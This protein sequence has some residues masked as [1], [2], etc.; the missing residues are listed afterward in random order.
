MIKHEPTSN[1][2]AAARVLMSL[3]AT[4]DDR[5]AAKAVIEPTGIA[6]TTLAAMNAWLVENPPTTV[7]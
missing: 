7:G 5:V 3:S 4:P 1:I 6:F 2:E